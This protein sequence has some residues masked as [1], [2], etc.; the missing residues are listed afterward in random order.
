MQVYPN[1][2]ASMSIKIQ[3]GWSRSWYCHSWV[4]HEQRF[5]R[6]WQYSLL[7]IGFSRIRHKTRTNT[8]L[9]TR[10]RSET[11]LR[12]LQNSTYCCNLHINGKEK[13]P[14]HNIETFPSIHTVSFIFLSRSLCKVHQPGNPTSNPSL[15]GAFGIS[16]KWGH[17]P[18]SYEG[19]WKFEEHSSHS[20][21]TA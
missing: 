6:V 14:I 9:T 16:Y 8:Y 2:G 5:G 21:R 20:K 19:N 7:S 4:G 1:L 11:F 18:P 13:P 3:Y 15:F 10:S 17:N 12:F